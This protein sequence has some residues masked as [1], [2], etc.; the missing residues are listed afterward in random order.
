MQ[1]RALALSRRASQPLLWV[2]V[3]GIGLAAACGVVAVAR[4][5]IVPPEGDLSKVIAFD[6][7][8]GIYL[9]TLAFIAPLARFSTA[10]ER[11][12]VAASVGL[13]SARP[14]FGGPTRPLTRGSAPVLS[15]L[16]WLCYQGRSSVARVGASPA[17]TV[18]GPGWT[19]T[20]AQ[21]LRCGPSGSSATPEV[22]SKSMVGHRSR[23]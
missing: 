15:R 14:A 16:P 10:G 2:G 8:V 11:R 21:R 3:L 19:E 13:G 17:T 5:L 20:V 18:E 6:L 23:S 7:A 4:G 12:W 9:I 22:V 1:D